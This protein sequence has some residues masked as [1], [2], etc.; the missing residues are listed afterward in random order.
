METYRQFVVDNLPTWLGNNPGAEDVPAERM[1]E[2]VE[3]TTGCIDSAL[4]EKSEAD[5]IEVIEGASYDEF[6]FPVSK[7]IFDPLCAEL[8]SSM[9]EG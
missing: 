1:D 5:L 6:V 7:F 9:I 4:E 2:I 8:S 3:F